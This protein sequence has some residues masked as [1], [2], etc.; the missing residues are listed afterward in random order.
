[1]HLFEACPKI[2]FGE[3]ALDYLS[4]LPREKVLLVTD[5]FMVSSGAVKTVTCRL[6]RL[7]LEYAVFSQ[8]EPDPSLETIAAGLQQIFHEKPD[9]VIA[10]GGGSA[11][12]AA[13]AMLYFCTRFKG[14]LMGKQYIH[15]PMFIAVPT[16]SGTGSEV[17]S[18]AVVSDRQKNVK[19]PLSHR[20]MIPEVA[21]LDPEFTKTLPADMVAFTGMDVLTHAVEAFVSGKA[22]EFTDLFAKDAAEKVLRCL[23][24]LYADISN[25]VLRE[26]M[27]TASTMAG[28]AF[29]NS[30]LGLC[31][32]IA[33]TIGAEF[34]L[35]HGKANAI[36]LPYIIA[37]NAGLGRKIVTGLQ[38]RYAELAR[39]MGVGV[40]DDEESCQRLVYTVQALC[41]RFDIPRSFEAA[42]IDRDAFCQKQE[43][44]IRKI[45]EDVCTKANPVSVTA[46]DISKLL[47]AIFDERLE[48]GV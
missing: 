4:E 27:F 48:V 36:I 19:I 1:M 3:N 42:G 43:R 40:A 20:S 18:Y 47:E 11:I 21:I 44:C 45:L 29:T 24:G 9:I 16:T 12:D 7:G 8:V 41:E 5:P 34:R 28:L 32:G 17:T 33:H 14:I 26:K 38:G 22:N 10:L 30:G 25:A 15:K 35:P 46:Q 37:F 31:H 2:Y 13:K 23:P 6:D 39:S